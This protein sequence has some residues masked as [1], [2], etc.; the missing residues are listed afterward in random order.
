MKR[1]IGVTFV[2]CTLAFAGIGIGYA[3]W[4]EELTIEGSVTMGS[5]DP[6]FLSAKSSDPRL[7]NSLDPKEC[8]SWDT[9]TGRWS[10]DTYDM[11]VGSTYAEVSRDGTALS[12]MIDNAYPCYYGSVLACIKNAGTVPVKIKSIRLVEIGKNGSNKSLNVGLEPRTRYY[13]DFENETKPVDT[14][15][16]ISPQ[17]K[18]LDDFSFGF[19]SKG[20]TGR[21]INA[22][23][24]KY[25][26]ICIH[27]EEG[28]QQNT[29]YSFQIQIDF[30][31]WNEVS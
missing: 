17:G 3:N 26:I 23:K 14:S 31:N 25:A 6:I 5:I 7:F 28:A 19:K 20:S 18:V 12:I 1:K 10:G 30:C 29:T 27:V 8:G 9:S 16:H 4:S 21:V 11:D 22:G 24:E 13:V 2:L 15:P